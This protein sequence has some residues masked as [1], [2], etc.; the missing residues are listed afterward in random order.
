MAFNGWFHEE[1]QDLRLEKRAEAGQQT[2]LKSRPKTLFCQKVFWSSCRLPGGKTAWPDY[3]R[4]PD[5]G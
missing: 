3:G 1:E 2:T 4:S 5:G